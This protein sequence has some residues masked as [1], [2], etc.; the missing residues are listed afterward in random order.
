LRETIAGGQ[1]DLVCH[2]HTHVARQETVGRTLVVNPG[3]LYRANPHRFALV[4]LPALEVTSI[5]L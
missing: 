5:A 3:A 4:D 1:Y 2:G